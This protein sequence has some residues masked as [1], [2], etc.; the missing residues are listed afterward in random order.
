MFDEPAVPHP[1]RTANQHAAFRRGMRFFVIGSSIM[2][3]IGGT[4]YFGYHNLGADQG[5]DNGRSSILSRS[6]LESLYNDLKR[7]VSESQDTAQ[8]MLLA[9]SRSTTIVSAAAL[10]VWDY[11]Q[12]LNAHYNAKAEEEEAMRTCHLRSA[13]RMLNAMQTNGGLYIKLGQ[14]LSSVIL[15]PPEWTDT[16]KPLQDQ[17]EPTPLNELEA[18]FQKETNKTF[19]QAFEWL[20]PKP[21]G[22]ASLAQVHR[23]KDRETGQ[24]LA[25]KMLHPNV[26]RFSSVDMKM[27]TILV[28][29]VKRV[30]PDFSFEWLADEMNKNMPLELDFRHEAENSRRAQQNFQQYK[31][32]SV[33]FPQVPWVFRR[34]LA[35]EFIEGARPDNLQY[36]AEHKIDRN[37]VSQELSKIFSQMLYLHG[38]FHADPHGGNVLIRPRQSQSRSRENFEIVL[39]D[40]GL[41]FEIDAQLRVN[42]ARFWL[43]LL[44]RATPQVQ[45]QR[46]HY[47]KLVGNIDD[48][49]YP[50]LESAITGRSGLE[51]S[52]AHN[53]S[54]IK[55]K[56]RVS[57]LLDMDGGA[58]MTEEEQEHIR[59]TVMEKEG[60][61]I[62]VLEVLRKVPRAMLM[63]LKIND[64]LRSLDK[65]LYTT[66]GPAR[67]FIITARY[68]ALAVYQDDKEKIKEEWRQDGF[69]WPLVKYYFS[70]W[71][72]YTYFYHGLMLLER[73]SDFTARI[74]KYLAYLRTFYS[75][76]FDRLAAERAAAGIEEQERSAKRIKE[77]QSRAMASLADNATEE[78]LT[79]E[80]VQPQ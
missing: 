51:G 38:F 34:V 54:G 46:R 53:P 21:L 35:M 59:K 5:E 16:L 1:H 4:V 17:N 62:N 18:L 8:F 71:W 73:C 12:T 75:V 33:T 27:V 44:S 57:S 61:F 15:L 41:Y 40:H 49:L 7:G 37:R 10:C 22:V 29:W 30:F 2:I 11:R 65:N 47:A 20:D 77:D 9:L 70:S 24:I 14:H 79:K 66:H 43:S 25:I 78:M 36:L 72:N 68:S 23:A 64:L 55:G 56:T 69:T 42:Y 52:D 13:N 80:H 19:E 39:L 48:D 58:I 45:R 76:G 31:Y 74:H 60:M 28:G 6:G 32:T 67:P 63:V 3:V 50:I 26:E